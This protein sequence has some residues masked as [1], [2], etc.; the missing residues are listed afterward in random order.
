MTDNEKRIEREQIEWIFGLTGGEL[1]D[2]SWGYV[3]ET[4][5]LSTDPDNK[6]IPCDAH[7]RSVGAYPFEPDYYVHTGA[8]RYWFD[9]AP[10]YVASEYR[11]Q[12]VRTAVTCA[13]FGMP[14][15][16]LW[17]V[18]DGT[19]W[20][21]VAFYQSSGETE[22][23]GQHE[24]TDKVTAD[25]TA[26]GNVCVLCDEEIGTEHGYIYLGDGWGEAVYVRETPCV[27]FEI[28]DHGV[29]GE[30]YFPGCGVSHT[31]FTD[32]ATGI[33]DSAR[34]AAE[35]AADSMAQSL[36]SDIEIPEELDAAIRELSDEDDTHATCSQAFI[37]D[38]GN[39]PDDFEAWHETCEM[40]HYVSIRYR[41]ERH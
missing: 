22:C 19:R 3:H 24:D 40:H 37:D 15:E 38:A 7:G 16:I 25:H 32:V 14:P 11:D 39:G 27:H 35:D 33:G 4:S 1:S 2:A 10:E 28:I 18:T 41:V 17:D 23:P 12:N 6:C 29:D 20:K 9:G 13:L 8:F 36:P 31:A 30:S 34:A 21:R 5:G 26:G